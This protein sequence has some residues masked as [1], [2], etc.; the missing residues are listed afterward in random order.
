MERD[1]TRLGISDALWPSGCRRA[2]VLVHSTLKA[3]LYLYRVG[4]RLVLTEAMMSMM[5]MISVIRASGCSQQSVVSSPSSHEHEH[6]PAANKSPT[7]A[8]CL[9]TSPP[10]K[11]NRQLANHY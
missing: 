3:F 7:R 5:M 8:N 4:W 1:L 2:T 6:E 11:A 10:G 9:L